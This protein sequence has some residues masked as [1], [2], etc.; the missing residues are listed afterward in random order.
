[1]SNQVIQRY[2]PN[3]GKARALMFVL[4][5]LYL[6]L[7]LGMYFLLKDTLES[8]ALVWLAL[9]LLGLV[10][11]V[12]FPNWLKNNSKKLE[13][14]ADGVLIATKRESQTYK[15]S[16]I[17]YFDLNGVGGNSLLVKFVNGRAVAFLYPTD[18]Q[19][20][21]D[22]FNSLKN[23]TVAQSPE[24]GVSIQNPGTVST[25]STL[26]I[27]AFIFAFIFPIVGLVL[28]YVAQSEILKSNGRLGGL[29]LARAAIAISTIV[30]FIAAIAIFFWI[31]ILTR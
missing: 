31:L 1:M 17:S 24:G 12:I 15:F 19:K 18:P 14:S 21:V 5:G 6:A 30:I 9:P 25:S 7:G 26:S 23:G 28:G 8:G 2:V 10:M 29:G 13:L 27:V 16:E 3:V 4:T 11:V 22:T 20:L